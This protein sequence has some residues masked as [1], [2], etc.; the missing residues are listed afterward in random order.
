MP[1]KWSK[2]INIFDKCQNKNLINTRLV[3]NWKKCIG[4]Y[5]HIM[6]FHICIKTKQQQHPDSDDTVTFLYM[7]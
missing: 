7:Y 6:S 5:F 2:E 1:V 4:I 3:E